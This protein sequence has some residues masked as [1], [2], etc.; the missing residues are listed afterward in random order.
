LWLVNKDFVPNFN[1][2]LLTIAVLQE[3][4]HI[5]LGVSLRRPDSLGKVHVHNTFNGCLRVCH[6]E[7]YLAKCPTKDDANDNEESD[8]EPG[9]N[10]TI[11]LILVHVKHLFSAM[12]VEPGLVLLDYIGSDVP[13]VVHG[14]NLRKNVNVFW[15]LGSLKKYPVL[16][17]NMSTSQMT[18]S[19]QSATHLAGAK[20]A[21]GT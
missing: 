10:W 5:F 15:D 11:G 4:W 8:Q 21:V 9:Y 1:G 14:P 16:V 7:I 3:L 18:A 13:L 6:D 12:Q 2:L 17:V 20:L 19:T